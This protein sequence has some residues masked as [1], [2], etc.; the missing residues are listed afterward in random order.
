MEN[1]KN[2]TILR[3]IDTRLGDVPRTTIQKKIAK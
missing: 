2:D 3:N 1:I